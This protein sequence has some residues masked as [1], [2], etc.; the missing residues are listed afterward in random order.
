MG[1]PLGPRRR[2]AGEG[3][4]VLI[5]SEAG[6][7]KSRL[8]RALR[9]RIGDDY[10]AVSHYGSPHHTNSALFPVTRLLGRAAGF[11]RADAPETRLEKLEALL[12]LGTADLQ[13]VVPLIAALLSVPTDTRYPPPDLNP[14]LQK[15]KTLEALIHQLQGLAAHQPVLAIYEDAHWMDPTTLELLDLVVQR[16]ATLPV[17]V[18][19]SF[20]PE[21]IPPWTGYPHVVTLTLSRLNRRQGAA[22]V[23]E[24]TGGKALPPEVLE[25]ILMK[26]DG[27]PL[28]VEELTK[29]VITS[30]LLTDT[31]DRFE[32]TDGP[33]T[34]S[35]LITRE[36]IA[37][38]GMVTLPPGAFGYVVRTTAVG[39]RLGR[40]DMVRLAE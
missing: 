6:V 1:L 22:I 16:V 20:R 13:E 15:Q 28:F 25:Q 4:V 36:R 12:A 14:W 18:V 19:I 38:S 23:D 5:A 30:G 39:T 24:I 37:Q 29:T 26:T 34:H 21:F 3:Q 8:V 35:D 40:K 27:V 11:E 32:L 9:E 17:L 7:G 2:L 31:G 33:F 10:M